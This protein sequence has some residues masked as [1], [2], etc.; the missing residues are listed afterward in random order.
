MDAFEYESDDQSDGDGSSSSSSMELTDEFSDG[1]E[2][3]TSTVEADVSQ[4]EEKIAL[5]VP[6]M[7][8]RR[9]AEAPLL[10]STKQAFVSYL[11]KAVA[12]KTVRAVHEQ[13]VAA[14]LQQLVQLRGFTLIQSP[15][16]VH[17]QHL[18]ALLTWKRMKVIVG[19]AGDRVISIFLV[20]GGKMGI[21][22]ARDIQ[23]G[24][25]QFNIQQVLIVTSEGVTPSASK[26]LLQLSCFVQ[27]FY[28]H[29]LSTRY[30]EHALI[31]QQRCL[32]PEESKAFLI[33]HRTT[34]DKLPRMSPLDPVAK[35]YGWRPSSII[36]SLRI[37]GGATEPYPYWRVIL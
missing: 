24:I 37:M 36:E 23:L 22:R 13:K 18:K 30:T 16:P 11:Q 10:D 20:R 9:R 5:G 12:P 25:T 27:F 1:C 32:S 14:V 19:A 4:L 33:K 7:E 6:E 29:E 35:F 3:D 2:S 21:Q 15:L 31:P 34:L 26:S 17:Y 8:G 28:M